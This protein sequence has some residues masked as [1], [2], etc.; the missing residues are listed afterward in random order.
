MMSYFSFVQ[1]SA[2]SVDMHRIGADL[3]VH[4]AIHVD[5]ACA[6]WHAATK[7]RRQCLA[8]KPGAALALCCVN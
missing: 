8:I 2:M 1:A 5:V 7:Q 6:A 4:Y 3:F